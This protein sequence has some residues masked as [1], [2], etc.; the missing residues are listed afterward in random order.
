MATHQTAPTQFASVKGFKLAYRR[1]GKQVGV[2]LLFLTHFRGTMDLIDPLLANS[3][4]QTREVILFDN[5]GC[6]H[7]E[8]TIQDT[9]QESGSTVVDFLAVISVPKVDI[10]GF[11]LG[12]M[13]AQCIVVEHTQVLNKLILAGTQSSYTEGLV[14]GA[15]EVSEISG[16]VSPN[17]QD[18]MKL[19][20]F[21]SETSKALGHAWWERTKERKVQGGEGKRF[22]NK[23]G[24]QAQQAAIGRFVS[25]A[26]FFERLQQVHIPVLVTNGTAD[27]M[28]PTSNS[29]I[30]QRKLRN[31][32]L[33]IYPDSGHGHLYQIPES[34]AKQLELFLD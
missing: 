13:I 9:L 5:A 15:P 17:E 25:D 1:F 33:H 34:Y 7:S 24:G 18:M 12:G 10:L 29:N 32:Q 19:F 23:A 6:G 27:I 28:T 20:F 3:I 4:A 30:L 14:L 26:G 21:P 16:S 11:S 2:P 22:V 8:G 31:A